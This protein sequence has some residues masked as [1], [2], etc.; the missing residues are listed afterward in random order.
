VRAEKN[1]SPATSL[2]GSEHRS[3][4]PGRVHRRT[5][6]RRFI[7]KGML[8]ARNQ[9]GQVRMLVRMRDFHGWK[10]GALWEDLKFDLTHFRKI[11]RLGLVGEKSWEHGMSVFCRP[12][13]TARI[14]YFDQREAD[15]AEAW[16][17]ADLAEEQDT[18]NIS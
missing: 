16:I 7:V 2:P 6:L 8:L 1:W 17:R 5:C 18:L 10:A 9:H 14:C 4:C 3:A 12:F 11:E 15:R 13:T